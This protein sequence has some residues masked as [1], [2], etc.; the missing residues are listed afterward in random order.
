MNNHYPFPRW[1]PPH[2]GSTGPPGINVKEAKDGGSR[3]PHQHAR[4]CNSTSCHCFP[5]ISAVSFRNSFHTQC[6]GSCLLSVPKTPFLLQAFRPRLVFQQQLY[7]LHQTQHH[8]TLHHPS[9][10]GAFELTSSCGSSKHIR[11]IALRCFAVVLFTFQIAVYL[12]TTYLFSIISM[13]NEGSVPSSQESTPISEYP[14]MYSIHSRVRSSVESTRAPSPMEAPEPD[15]SHLTAEE[16]AQIR[17]VMERA[18]HMQHE[19]S[20]RAR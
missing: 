9:A 16:V 3:T 20:T 5:E 15:L 1:T 4:N 6:M 10:V 12:F 2:T 19:E 14:S 17:S 13:G 11:Y 8:D 18:R 7:F